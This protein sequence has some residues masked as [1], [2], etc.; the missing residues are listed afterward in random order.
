MNQT[1]FSLEDCQKTIGY[2]FVNPHLLETALTHS[3]VAANRGVSNERLE[4]L[5][6]AILGMVVCH[7]LFERFP[8][9]LEGELTKIKSMIVSRRTCARIAQDLHMQEFLR[10][11]KGMFTQAKLPL[12][13]LAAVY[14]SL[15]GAIFVDGGMEPAKDFILRTMS[16][17]LDQADA[18]KHQENYKSILQ[19]H[20]Q[21][22]METTPYYELLDEKGPDHSKCFEIA[23]VIGTQ[24]FP[25]AWGPSKKEAE[26]L[27][28]LKALQKLEI[29]PEESPPASLPAE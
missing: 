27:A 15:I 6:D 28:A 2:Q 24:R 7:E 4:F 21:R 23:V 29:L 25:G 1:N 19:Q 16:P 12:S 5:G 22:V 10:I 18:D 9:Y 3:S 20:A 13:C 26:Q 17:L 11:G 8:H 14:E